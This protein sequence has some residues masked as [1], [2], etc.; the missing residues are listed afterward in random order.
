MVNG[1]KITELMHEKGIKNKEIAAEVGISESMM[2][3]IVKELREPNVTTLSR[4][5]KVLGVTVDELIVQM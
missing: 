2:T 4:I 1:K 5:A 3:Y